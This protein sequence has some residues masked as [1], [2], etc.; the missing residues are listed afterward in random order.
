MAVRAGVPDLVELLTAVVSQCD[1]AVVVDSSIRKYLKEVD[2]TAADVVTPAHNAS[3]EAARAIDSA[4]ADL[5]GRSAK[6]AP[7][8]G[9]T[10]FK[11]TEVDGLLEARLPAR[12]TIGKLEGWLEEAKHFYWG[13]IQLLDPLLEWTRGLRKDAEA[14]LQEAS[15]LVT[16][17]TAE[18]T[19]ELAQKIY[20]W[21]KAKQGEAAK[22]ED[23]WSERIEKWGGDEATYL[24]FHT[25]LRD[26]L[27]H[28]VAIVALALMLDSS[29]L[30]DALADEE[31]SQSP[32]D[33]QGLDPS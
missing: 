3:V 13:S 12:R 10:I 27:A 21:A 14:H 17:G 32:H 22:L 16:G 26:H 8:N 24:V 4:R 28:F 6:L 9:L 7:L 20:A 19:K 15:Q 1:Q 5:R 23:A 31:P 18:D 33:H 25:A 2:E 30:A 29:Q 11:S